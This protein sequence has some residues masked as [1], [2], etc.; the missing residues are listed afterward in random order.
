MKIAN[1]VNVV[2]DVIVETLDQRLVILLG[3]HARLR[4]RDAH[5]V[6][7]V[8]RHKGLEQSVQIGSV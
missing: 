8:H 7:R 4:M 5:D 1:L 2:V 6:V 3:L